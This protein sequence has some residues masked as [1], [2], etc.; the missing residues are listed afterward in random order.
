MNTYEKI[1]NLL[2]EGPT[3]E[4]WEAGQRI[5]RKYREFNPGAARFRPTAASKKT[6]KKT[7]KRGGK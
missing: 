2:V 6:T 4:E 1:Y 7:T 3:P 5:F